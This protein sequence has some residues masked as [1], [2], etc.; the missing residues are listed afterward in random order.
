MTYQLHQQFESAAS[1]DQCQ[2]CHACDY[3][4]PRLR[5]RVYCS[6]LEH[7]TEIG[8]NPEDVVISELQRRQAKVDGSVLE[9]IWAAG[10]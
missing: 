8:M 10:G 1:V 2:V 4:R 9:L 3:G 6:T 5:G 7:L